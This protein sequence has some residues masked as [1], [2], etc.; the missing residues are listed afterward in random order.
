MLLLP[1]P[2]EAGGIFSVAWGSRDYWLVNEKQIAPHIPV[3]D[4]SRRADGSLSRD[5]FTF[6]NERNVYTL[7][8]L[9]MKR[10]STLSNEPP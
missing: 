5:D 9:S 1:I 7:G 2:C 10:H 8:L 4:K 6:D 3:I